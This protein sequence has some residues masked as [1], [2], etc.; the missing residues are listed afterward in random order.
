MRLGKTKSSNLRPACLIP[1]LNGVASRGRNL[2]LNRALSLVLH[3]HGAR[4]YLV[5]VA[6]VPDLEA[7]QIAAA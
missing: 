6:D 4:R 2:E 3:E 1:F 7:D 5:V